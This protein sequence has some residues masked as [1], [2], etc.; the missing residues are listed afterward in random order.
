MSLQ[1]IQLRIHEFCPTSFAIP[2]AQTPA[3]EM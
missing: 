3:L 2:T 1:Q